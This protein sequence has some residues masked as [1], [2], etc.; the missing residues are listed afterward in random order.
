MNKVI[1]VGFNTE[2]KA[3]EGARALYDMHKDGTLT[4]YNHAVV[5]KEPHGKVAVREL[6]EGEPIATVGG[7]LTGGLIGLL[8]GPIGAAMGMGTGTLIGAAFDLSREGINSDFVEDVGAHLVDPGKA[9]LI[10]EL[11]ENWQVPLDTRMEALGGKVMRKTLTEIDDAYFER[12]IEANKKELAVLEAEKLA[13]VKL[14]EAKKTSQKAAKLQA[15][16]DTQKRNVADKESALAAKLQSVKEEGRE[17]IAVLEAQ[18]KTASA[19]SKAA[20]ERRLVEVRSDYQRRIDNLTGTIEGR[21]A[22][23][24]KA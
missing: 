18:Q 21:K 20:L 6:P 4:L 13:E 5:V 14:A 7:M 10:A 19:D 12:E 2:A 15:K 11:D 23:S 24:V 16:I 8:G 17:K 1:Y 3:Y 22:A 9:A